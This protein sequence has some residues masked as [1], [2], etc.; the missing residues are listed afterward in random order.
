MKRGR[1]KYKEM[2]KS[3][4]KTETGIFDGLDKRGHPFRALYPL[5]WTVLSKFHGGSGQEYLGMLKQLHVGEDVK[6][7]EIIFRTKR[8]ATVGVL[9]VV[10]CILAVCAD[11]FTKEEAVLTGDAARIQKPSYG[12]R[13]LHADLSVRM[14][15]EDVLVDEDISMVIPARQYTTEEKKKILREAKTYINDVYLGK[16]PSAKKVSL[17]LTLPETVEGTPIKIRWSCEDD[18][19]LEDGTLQRTGMAESI[20]TILYGVLEWDELAEKVEYP[21]TVLPPD[22]SDGAQGLLDLKAALV[23]TIEKS[24]TDSVVALPTSIGDFSVEYREAEPEKKAPKI[25]L[26]GVLAVFVCYIM[27]GQRL[28][29]AVEMREHQ[30]QMDYPDVLSRCALLLGAGLTLQGSFRKMVEEYRSSN[31]AKRYVY[32]EMAVTLREMENGVTEAKA[33]ENFGKRTQ[34]LSY[35]KF[36]SLI[37]QN[38]RKG[39]KHLL[40]LLEN[41]RINALAER[42]EAAKRLGEQAGTKLLIPMM[43]MLVT[44]FIIILV[45][46]FMSF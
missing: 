21:V 10:M 20:E 27:M 34:L 4:E 31:T 13:D 28:K 39:S 11:I 2:R 26:F 37:S 29:N 25:L 1:G 44:V 41:E 38:L 14:T 35:M 18:C 30:M 15:G 24:S 9:A 46:A 45:P 12:E 43:L 6:R 33:V 17:P 40:Y 23:R 3:K 36:A 16:N 5:V 19:I 7:E 32:E 42:K 22:S 8:A